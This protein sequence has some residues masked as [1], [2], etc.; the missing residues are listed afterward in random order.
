M[1]EKVKIS[2]DDLQF[3]ILSLLAEG[4]VQYT[5]L[6]NRF[7]PVSLTA[8]LL[9]DLSSRGIIQGGLEP[10]SN[11]QL[12]KKGKLALYQMQE[13]REQSAQKEADERTQRRKDRCIQFLSALVAAVLTWLLGRLIP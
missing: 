8:D 10:Y 9:S 12:S 4:P 1:K 6:L 2:I 7:P 5:D 13:V 3:Q 11:V